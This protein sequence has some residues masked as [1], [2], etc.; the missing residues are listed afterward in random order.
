MD[1]EQVTGAGSAMV[2]VSAVAPP[3]QREIPTQGEILRCA[4]LRR[5]AQDDNKKRGRVN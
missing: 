4:C 5:Q 2:E 1:R 3:R